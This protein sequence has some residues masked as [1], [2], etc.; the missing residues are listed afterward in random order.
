M[1]KN[2]TNSPILVGE[3]MTHGDI[4]NELQTFDTS[5]FFNGQVSIV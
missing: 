2:V 5:R 1:Q 3:L 4:N